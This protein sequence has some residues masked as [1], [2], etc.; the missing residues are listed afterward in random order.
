MDYMPGMTYMKVTGQNLRWSPSNCVIECLGNSRMNDQKLMG[1]ELGRS[2]Q[3]LKM[4][5]D[6]SERSER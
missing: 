3:Y 6:R 5:F 1:T 4:A 2:L